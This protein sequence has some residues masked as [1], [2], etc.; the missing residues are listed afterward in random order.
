MAAGNQGIYKER[1]RSYSNEHSSKSSPVT[2]SNGTLTTP[3]SSSSKKCKT[4]ETM[5]EV[6][7]KGSTTQEMLENLTISIGEI[8]KDLAVLKSSKCA[9]DTIQNELKTLKCKDAE[10]SMKIKLLSA[11]V[12]KQDLRIAQLEQS[13]QA[14]QRNF[15]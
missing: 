10:N 14:M 3:A 9:H 4:L 15:R 11:T 7:K 5:E 2:T 6:T 8:R 13:L 1:L 12:I